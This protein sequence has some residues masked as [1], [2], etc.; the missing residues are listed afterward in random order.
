MGAGRYDVIVVGARVAGATTAMLL[1]R[2]GLRVLAVDRVSFPRD[3]ISSHQLHVPGVALLQ[4]WGLVHHLVAAGTPPS[5]RVRLDVGG[6]LVM[7]GQYAPYMGVD[8]IYSPRRT[9]LD[10]ILVDAARKSGAEVRENFRVAEVTRSDGRVTGIRGRDR[11]GPLV[12]ETAALVIGA[13]GKRSFVADAVG[14]RRY[15]ERP[16]QAFV[17]YS[18][19]SGVPAPGWEIYQRPGRAVAVY[20]TNDQLTMIYMAAPIA[21]FASERTDLEGNYLRALDL[22]GDLGDRVRSGTRAERLRTTPDQPN[23]FRQSHGPGWALVGDA[24]VVMDS[25]SAQGMTH[26]LRD[27]DH[28]CAAV[29]A[30]LGGSRPLAAALQEHQH[31]R[32]QAI[33]GMYDFTL[34]LASFPPLTSFR[35]LFYAAVAGDQRQTDRLI[36]VLAGTVPAEEYFSPAA[37]L[38]VLRLLGTQKLVRAEANEVFTTCASGV[39]PDSPRVEPQ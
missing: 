31:R 14:A 32:D 1:A 18:Y 37:M 10:T 28:L 2:Q 4:R 11:G 6:G 34:D 27:A 30:G 13:D 21:E 39:L 25:I 7:D 17:T 35:R 3:T 5:R 16:V 12:S 19:W 24:G 29:V 33:R 9:V 36:G 26:A 22:C 20:P 23:V 15:H 38:S 8:V